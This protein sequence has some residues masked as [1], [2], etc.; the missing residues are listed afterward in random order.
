[1]S[2]NNDHGYF[3]LHRA[4]EMAEALGIVNGPRLNLNQSNMSEE[5]VSSIKRTAWGLFQIDT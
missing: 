2:G 5:M 1:M 4:V 3:M